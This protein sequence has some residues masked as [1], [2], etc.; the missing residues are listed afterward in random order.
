MEIFGPKH[1]RIE[2]ITET[3]HFWSNSLEQQ[4]SGPIL[5]IIMAESGEV[6]MDKNV[7]ECTFY[8]FGIGLF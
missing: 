4:C 8:K 5:T 3:L 1:G 6:Y 2:P 7:K